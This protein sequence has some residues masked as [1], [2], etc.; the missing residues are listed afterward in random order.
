VWIL[1][2]TIIMI[3]IIETLYIVF[4]HSSL[5]QLQINL[6]PCVAILGWFGLNISEICNKLD[7]MNHSC[8]LQRTAFYSLFFDTFT[9]GEAPTV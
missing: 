8:R 2:I 6:E 5:M 3:Q 7:N 9:A 4:P 1:T